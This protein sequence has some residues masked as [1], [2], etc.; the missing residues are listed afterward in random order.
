MLRVCVCACVR[1]CVCA[2]VQLWPEASGCFSFWSTRS[3]NEKLNR[4]LRLDYA[5]ASAGVAEE[6]T[7][8][9]LHD[10]AILYEYAPKGDHAPTLV[11]FKTA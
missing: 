5:V 10:S 11:S 2:C 1:V 7:P 8:I 6:G 4:G 9:Q 3:G